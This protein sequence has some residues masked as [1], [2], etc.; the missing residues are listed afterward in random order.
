MSVRA[1][2]A[3]HVLRHQLYGFDFSSCDCCLAVPALV[4]LPLSI[5]PSAAVLSTDEARVS[6]NCCTLCIDPLQRRLQQMQE[7][8]ENLTE[9]RN[10]TPTNNPKL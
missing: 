7:K 2:V 8:E 5:I 9:D 1:S 3:R 4:V 6:D 10:P